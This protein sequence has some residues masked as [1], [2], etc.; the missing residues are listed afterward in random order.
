V[1]KL[2]VH[3]DAICD[4]YKHEDSQV[5]YCDGVTDGNVVHMAF[6]DRG[7]A[8]EWKKKYFR[9]DYKSCPQHNLQREFED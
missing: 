8:L 9:G 5:I 7:K 3:R 2:L 6:S 4:C 1:S